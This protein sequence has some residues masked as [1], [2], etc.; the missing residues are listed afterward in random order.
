MSTMTLAVLREGEATTE[1]RAM[2]AWLETMIAALF[3]L[4]AVV[5]VSFVAAITGLV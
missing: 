1:P 4:A 2:S 5:S 3:T